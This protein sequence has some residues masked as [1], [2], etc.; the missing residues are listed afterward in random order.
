MLR[1]GNIFIKITIEAQEQTSS[2][3]EGRQIVKIRSGDDS[4]KEY[5]DWLDR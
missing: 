4:K 5:E 3:R 2:T 1:F